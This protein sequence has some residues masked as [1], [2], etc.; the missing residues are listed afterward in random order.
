MHP[1]NRIHEQ[2][3]AVNSYVYVFKCTKMREKNDEQLT[4]KKNTKI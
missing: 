2:K 3:I 4:N 1:H